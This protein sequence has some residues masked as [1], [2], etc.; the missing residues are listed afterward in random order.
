MGADT[1]T[2]TV[3]ELVFAAINHDL[4]KMGDGEEY[5]HIPSKDEWR[6][7]IWVKCI[8]SIKRLHICQFQIGQFSY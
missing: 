3:E 4:G 5:A 6:K 7:R 8:N 1:T 2:Y